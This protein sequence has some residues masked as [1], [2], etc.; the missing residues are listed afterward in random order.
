MKK[1]VAF[2]LAIVTACS[3]GAFATGCSDD[4]ILVQTNAFFAPF[5]YYDGS[6]IVGVDVDIMERVGEKMGSCPGSGRRSPC[7]WAESSGSWR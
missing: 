3:I 6:E 4:A 5:E 7:L 2:L 1:V